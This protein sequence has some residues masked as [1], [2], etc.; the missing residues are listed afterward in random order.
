MQTISVKEC[1]RASRELFFKGKLGA[2]RHT[3]C[4]NVYDDGSRCAVGAGL[5]EEIL[6]Q[7]SQKGTVGCTVYSLQEWNLIEVTA[8]ELREL[9]ELQ[10]RHD[11]WATTHSSQQGRAAEEK[12]F[13]DLMDHY[14]PVTYTTQGGDTFNKLSEALHQ[15]D[16]SIEGITYEH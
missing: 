4:Q 3:V 12:K 5:D 6:E 1:A 11:S 14:D 15:H 2:Q 8:G 16:G 7:L 10:K 9:N 13:L